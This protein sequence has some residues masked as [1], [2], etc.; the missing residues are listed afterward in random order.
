MENWLCEGTTLIRHRAKRKHRD[1]DI[2][3][4]KIL[5]MFGLNTARKTRRKEG[6]EYHLALVG[7]N[8]VPALG[9]VM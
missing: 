6:W 1:T 3:T 7:P 8:R 4:P 9:L 5:S 2:V